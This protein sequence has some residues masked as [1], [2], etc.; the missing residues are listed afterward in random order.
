MERP[1]NPNTSYDAAY[2]AYEQGV[3]DTIELNSGDKKET[4]IVKETEENSPEENKDDTELE[5]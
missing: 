4:A 5:N 3:T 1:T 2:F